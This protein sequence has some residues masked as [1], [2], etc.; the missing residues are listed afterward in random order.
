MILGYGILRF[1]RPKTPNENK[2]ILILMLA[3]SKPQ[4]DSMAVGREH[5]KSHD[6]PARVEK[7]VNLVSISPRTEYITI[8]I[9]NRYSGSYLGYSYQSFRFT[10]KE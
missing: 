5:L 6:P 10:L 3:S 9:L 2:M 1:R 7:G 4:K 8:L